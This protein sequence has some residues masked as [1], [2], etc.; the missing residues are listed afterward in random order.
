MQPIVI[1]RKPRFAAASLPL[2]LTY[3]KYRLY[4]KNPSR[5]KGRFWEGSILKVF[6]VI[7]V[8]CLHTTNCR[9]QEHGQVSVN[10]ALVKAAYLGD[11]ESLVELL[12][13]GADIESIHGGPATA[14]SDESGGYP[15][16]AARWTSLLA[17]IAGKQDVAAGYLIGRGANLNVKTVNGVT[18]LYYLA[19][20]REQTDASLSLARL[21]LRA[22]VSPF[23]KTDFLFCLYT[24]MSAHEFAWRMRHDELL[25][26]FEGNGQNARTGNADW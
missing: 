22:K 21:F 1:P 3:F 25:A 16:T 23:E 14:F 6:L 15:A 8:I 2:I 26:L 20:R 7:A 9:S 13:K 12:D 4:G 24:P 17:A 10:P 19:Q 5:P 18:P 11:V